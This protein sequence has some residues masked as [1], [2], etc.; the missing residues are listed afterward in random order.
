MFRG[1]YVA[2][3]SFGL[4]NLCCCH[5]LLVKRVLRHIYLSLACDLFSSFNLF[6][7]FSINRFIELENYK[8]LALGTSTCNFLFCGSRVILLYILGINL[9]VFLWRKLLREGQE[10]KSCIEFLLV[11][12]GDMIF[13]LKEKT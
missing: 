4:D 13:H 8:F 5:W 2:I 7:S 11:H 12:V 3:R 9:F 10:K 6:D 1:K